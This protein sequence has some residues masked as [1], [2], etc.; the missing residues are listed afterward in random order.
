MLET[1][2]EKL[3]HLKSQSLTI[4]KT[5]ECATITGILS[6]CHFELGFDNFLNLIYYYFP[7]NLTK[8]PIITFYSII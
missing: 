8:S 1:T 2:Y 4:K 6:S 5:L 7:N 3:I